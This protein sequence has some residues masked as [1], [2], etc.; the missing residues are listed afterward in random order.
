M[1]KYTELLKRY[2]AFLEVECGNASSMAAVHGW[3]CPPEIVQKGIDFRQEIEDE[4]EAQYLCS[5][6]F[7]EDFAKQVEA[8]TWEKGL[9][10]IYMNEKRQIVE[11]WADGT[12]NII[13][14]SDNEN[15]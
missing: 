1:T 5:E 15:N 14:D 12:V 2:I 10:K 7:R 13:K 9:P 8:D 6:K 11:H 4:E 3:K